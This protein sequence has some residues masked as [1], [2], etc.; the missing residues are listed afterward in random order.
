MFIIEDVNPADL[1]DVFFDKF[2][3]DC[4]YHMANIRIQDYWLLWWGF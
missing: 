3:E 1:S 2:I 4:D